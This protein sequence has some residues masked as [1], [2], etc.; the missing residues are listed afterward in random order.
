MAERQRRKAARESTQA[1]SRSL[2]A[3]VTRR[4]SLLWPGKIKTGSRPSRSERNVL[5]N[6]T[7]L[8]SVDSV[9][10][11]PLDNIE[12]TQ[13]FSANTSP[14]ASPQVIEGCENPFHH[15]SDSLNDSREQQTAVMGEFSQPSIP[16]ARAEKGKSASRPGRPALMAST[17]SF[18]QP[19]PPPK[20]LGL[21]PPR[22]PPPPNMSSPPT[23]MTSPTLTTER[24]KEPK[25]TRWWHDWLCGLTEG[26]DRGGD[27][28]VN[29]LSLSDR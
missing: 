3:D 20:P 12:E 7:A 27:D 26:S 28:Q 10:A 1:P 13:T 29:I 6:H 24:Q 5:G 2:V 22:T 25:E 16:A 15:P 17:S 23:P 9:D 21:P 8:A 19:P 14:A 18:T 4:A 11:V